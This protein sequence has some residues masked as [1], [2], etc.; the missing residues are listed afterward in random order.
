MRWHYSV[1]TRPKCTAGSG[2]A[3]RGR[4]SASLWYT[5]PLVRLRDTCVLAPAILLHS[6]ARD[7]IRIDQEA[8]EKSSFDES[9]DIRLRLL[10]CKV[11]ARELINHVFY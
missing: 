8:Q 1:S 5:H 3:E 7:C 11:I 2:K 4:L 9:H 10:R 6:V